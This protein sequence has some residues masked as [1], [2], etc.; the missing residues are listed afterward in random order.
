MNKLPSNWRGTAGQS[1]KLANIDGLLT[2]DAEHQRGGPPQLF[3]DMSHHEQ[4]AVLSAGKRRVLNRGTLL[5]KQGGAQDGIYLIESGR[6]KVFYIGP[7][8]REITLAYWHAGN[9]VGGPD[10]FE[11]GKHVWSGEAAANS[12]VLHLPGDLLRGMIKKIPALAINIID[13]LS[14]KGKCYSALAQMLGTR[15]PIERLAQLLLHLA[16]LYGVEE[17]HG[18]LIAAMFTHADLAHMTGVTRQSVTTTLKRFVDDGIVDWS[19]PNLVVK[20]FELLASIRDGNKAIS[21]AP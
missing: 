5:F 4:D 16:N 18:T 19:G 6:I 10:V 1:T 12:T 13:G 14:F 8:G 7:K 2:P 20:N 17:R 21:A 15:S 11:R 3:R 9:F